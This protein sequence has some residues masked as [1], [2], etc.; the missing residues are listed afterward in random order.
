MAAEKQRLLR[1][2]DVQQKT[3]ETLK[4]SDEVAPS[5]KPCLLTSMEGLKENVAD[6]PDFEVVLEGSVQYKGQRN[7]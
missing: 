3:K 4:I 7:R 1:T 6:N 5:M 2:I